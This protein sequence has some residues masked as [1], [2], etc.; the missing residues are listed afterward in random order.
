[1]HKMNKIKYGYYH[2]INS[3]LSEEI[4]TW[5]LATAIHVSPTDSHNK[6][7]WNT[8]LGEEEASTSNPG[9]S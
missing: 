4:K 5:L 6:A 7:E 9:L 8:W 2:V 3:T 1:M